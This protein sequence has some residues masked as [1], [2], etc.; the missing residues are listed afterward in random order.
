MELSIIVKNNKKVFNGLYCASIASFVG[1]PLGLFTTN[2]ILEKLNIS[3]CKKSRKAL[4]KQMSIGI[5][6][7]ALLGYLYGYTRP[8]ND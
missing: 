4:N 2:K 1:I 5:G 8:V 6:M 7:A 3:H